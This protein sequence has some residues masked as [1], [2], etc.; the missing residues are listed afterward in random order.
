MTADRV[1]QPQSAQLFDA[2]LTVLRGMGE[3]WREALDLDG[4]VATWGGLLMDHDH[5]EVCASQYALL[6]MELN[7][8]RWSGEILSIILYMG[9]LGC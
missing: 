7:Q 2:S 4:Y 3:Y 8:R 6:R 1:K 9:L 5:E